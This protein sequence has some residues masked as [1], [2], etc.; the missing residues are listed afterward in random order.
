MRRILLCTIIPL[1]LAGCK[2]LTGDQGNGE[3]IGVND[4]GRYLEPAPYG[5]VRIPA[6]TL[7]LGPMTRNHL[8]QGCLHPHHFIIPSIWMRRDHQ[9]RIPQFVHWVRDFHPAPEDAN[10]VSLFCPGRRSL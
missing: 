7:Q 4:R 3:L 2:A 1:L 8:R 9:Q 10:G 5:M 6:G